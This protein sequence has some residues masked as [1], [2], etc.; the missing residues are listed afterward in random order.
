MKY[1]VRSK[2]G[3]LEYESFGQ[4][5]KAW[6][7]GLIDPEDEILEEGHERW[8]K[9]NTFPLLANARRSGEQVWVGTW[10]IWTLIGVAGG[11]V[12]LW[13][14][15]GESLREK[16]IGLVVAFITAGLMLKVTMNAYAR[17]KPH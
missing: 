16:G 12:A 6:L 7:L 2:E 14:L 1:R 5:E 8:R 9:A 17:R 10:F 4:V 15:R 3:E 11:T 13:L